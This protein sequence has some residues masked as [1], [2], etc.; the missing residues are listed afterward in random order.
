[1]Y[2]TLLMYIMH[3]T[4]Y[5]RCLELSKDRSEVVLNVRGMGNR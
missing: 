2:D 3:Y 5:L 4:L 1:M